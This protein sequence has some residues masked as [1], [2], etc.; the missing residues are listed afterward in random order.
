MVVID[1]IQ[2]LKPKR[3]CVVVKVD[4]LVNESIS[5]ADGKSL[6]LMSV[7][8]TEK[9]RNTSKRG[10]VYSVPSEITNDGGWSN[11]DKHCNVSPGDMV[12]FSY[13]V[14][15]QYL[16]EESTGQRD[17]VLRVVKNLDSYYIFVPYAM[18]FMR[19]RNGIREALNGFVIGIK[20]ELPV[21]SELQ[22]STKKDERSIVVTI[23][24]AVGSE[25]EEWYQA[26]V[27]ERVIFRGLS[28]PI[29]ADLFNDEKLYYIRP[30]S[31]I[32]TYVK[33]A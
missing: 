27:G 4:S 23:P 16:H 19:E 13:D 32:A 15:A 18:M 1:N 17:G 20:P 14:I 7:S 11:V 28:L 9:S 24:S 26:S 2:N 5:F 30:K 31:I 12:F 22:I 29:D 10:T 33:Q 25:A 6:V 8:E 3:G 21:E